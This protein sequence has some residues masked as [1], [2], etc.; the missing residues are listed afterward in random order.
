[1]LS[2][3]VKNRRLV[4]IAA[5]A[6][7][8]VIALFGYFF[9]NGDSKPKVIVT[10]TTTTT[11]PPKNARACE[12]LTASSLLAGGIIPDV[13]PKTTENR[14]RCTYEDIGGEVNYI[15]LYVD[16]AGQCDVLISDAK[17]KEEV[18]EVGKNAIYTE[19]LDPTVIVPQES[20]CFFVQGSKTLVSKKA[21]LAIA[22][23]VTELLVAVDSSTTTTTQTT[24][25]LPEAT[26]STLP[27]QNTA[28]ITTAAS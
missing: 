14:K 28:V 3:T 7:V 25:V 19:V 16:A 21:V 20:R 26:V 24:I 5:A 11:L 23:S 1:M 10:T 2:Q 13:A 9:S 17:E 22:K 6:I 4:V 12:Y 27:G 8:T 15:T 18:P